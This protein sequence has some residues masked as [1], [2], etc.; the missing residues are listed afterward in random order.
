M[1]G[2]HLQQSSLALGAMAPPQGARQAVQAYARAAGVL[3]LLIIVIGLL[4]EALVRGTLVVAGDA[5]ATYARIMAAESTW[6]LG[7]AAELVLL[8]CAL[9]LTWIWY[10]LLRPVNKNLML[11]AVFFALTSLAIEAVSALSLEAVLTPLTHAMQGIDAPQR[12][13]MA[14][15]GVIAHAHAFGLALIFFGVECLI[16]GYLLRRSTYFPKAIGVMMQIAG[17]CYLVNSFCMVL[18]PALAGMLFP[19]ILLPCLVGEGAFCLWLLIKGV[20][21]AAWDKAGASLLA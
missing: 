10:L 7:I 14:Y 12:Q 19:A 21:L 9:A 11:L 17:T 18:A 2:A 13:A 8:V 6:R 20:D 4:D 16:V 5:A 15:G 3:Y 1:M